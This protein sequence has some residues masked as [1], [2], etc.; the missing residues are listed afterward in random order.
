MIFKGKVRD[1]KVLLK[2]RQEFREYLCELEGK[3]IVVI[4][5]KHDES[6]RSSHQNRYYWSII[7]RISKAFNELG[8]ECNEVDTH[9]LMT[10]KYLQA[11]VDDP[12][13]RERRTVTRSTTSLTVEE[14]SAY[15]D[16]IIMFCIQALDIVIPSADDWLE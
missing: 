12:I 13:T 3:D 15:M 5:D 7:R 1:G 8:H 2:F 14:F 4:V 16:S 6:K 11:Y 9:Q 10:S